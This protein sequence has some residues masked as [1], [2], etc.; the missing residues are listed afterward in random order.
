[1]CCFIE[2]ADVAGDSAMDDD[3]ERHASDRSPARDRMSDDNSEEDDKTETRK[4]SEHGGS[5]ATP[6]KRQGSDA[7]K[8]NTADGAD[9][10]S[11][12]RSPEDGVAQKE[13]FSKTE[14]PVD[15]TPSK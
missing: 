9:L 2:G 10:D 5:P 13:T 11:E 8:D 1:M 14:G 15:H 7:C 6:V 3:A 12:E 4:P